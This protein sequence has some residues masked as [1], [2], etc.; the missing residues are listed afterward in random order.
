MVYTHY[1]GNITLS[2][3][4]DE[5][6]NALGGKAE[7]RTSVRLRDKMD[8]HPPRLFACSNKTGNFIVSPV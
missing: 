7:Y 1:L 4:S 2:M 5:F 3:C 8:A 6:W